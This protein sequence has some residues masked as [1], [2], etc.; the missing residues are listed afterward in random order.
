MLSC[1]SVTV[2][3]TLYCDIPWV[4]LTHQYGVQPGHDGDD[5]KSVK[6]INTI[7]LWLPHRKCLVLIGHKY[8]ARHLNCKILS[9]VLQMSQIFRTCL[10]SSLRVKVQRVHLNAYVTTEWIYYTIIVLV[11]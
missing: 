10:I 2:Y 6:S 5:S 11:Y 1:L 3:F 7:I 4:S 9:R 8:W